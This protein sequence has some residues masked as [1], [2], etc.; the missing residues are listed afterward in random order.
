MECT[1]AQIVKLVV[2][3]W[4]DQ[5]GRRYQGTQRASSSWAP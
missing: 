4:S 5:R 1:R 3:D 2:D